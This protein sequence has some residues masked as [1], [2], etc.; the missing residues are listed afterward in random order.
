M[1]KAPFVDGYLAYDDIGDG[2]PV[3][4][5]HDGTLDRR[6]WV[7]QLHAFDGYRVLNV[8]AR[9]H[10]ESSTPTT[11]YL[12]G[13]DVTALLDHLGLASA[14]LVGQ[15]MGGTSALD[16][17]L[18]HPG[19]VAG[20]VLSGCGTSE[21]YWQSEFVVD[22]LKRQM[23][24]AFAR[25]TDGY[26]EMFLRLWVDGPHRRPD[27]VEPS[28][29]ER[30]REMAMHTATQH[31]RPN[32]VMP[33]K[34]ADTWNRLSDVRVPL[35]GIAGELDC[36]DIHDMLDRIVSTVPNA[37]LESFAGSGHMVNMEQP[38][39]FNEAVRRFLDEVS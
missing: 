5:L 13:D 2:P 16:T 26:V 28:I 22:L 6:V 7:Q 18:D 3:V 32:P 8:D 1:N 33:G 31:A 30:C 27:Q 4:F 25:D 17:A 10:G 24:C 23:E 39:R 19:R 11:E 36:T 37:K 34:A 15:A 35:L 12:R 29:R 38:E 9:G 21:Q 20:L 14:F